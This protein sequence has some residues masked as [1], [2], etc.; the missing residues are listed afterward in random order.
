M[1]QQC[2]LIVMIYITTFL[3]AG[4]LSRERYNILKV[5]FI[6]FI[7]TVVTVLVIKYIPRIVVILGTT[8]VI[9]VLHSKNKSFSYSGVIAMLVQMI[10][11]ITD[12]V[13]PNI[14]IIIAGKDIYDLLYGNWYN[15]YIYG[16]VILVLVLIFSSILG[17]II[18]KKIKIKE[19]DFNNKNHR[20]LVGI[21]A[22]NFFMIFLSVN[23]CTKMGFNNGL[24]KAVGL[25]LSIY[26]IVLTLLLFILIKSI[27]SEFDVKFE[28]EKNKQLKLYTQEIENLYNSLRDF[29][30]D[31][32][33]IL[34][35]MSLYIADK[36]ME[37]LEQYFNKYV[38][39]TDVIV[40]NNE[41]S[42]ANLQLIEVSELKSILAMK[43]IG[44][45]EKSINCSIRVLGKIDNINMDMLDLIRIVGIIFDNAIQAACEVE[46]GT[47]LCTISQKETFKI[48][49]CNNYSGEI[50]DISRFFAKGYTTKKEGSGIGLYNFVNII[51]K[52]NN[53]LYS[54]K[55]ENGLF[56]IQITVS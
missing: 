5:L 39:P 44:A 37:G 4:I 53:V 51:H 17:Y 15:I 9:S 13:I 18:N 24:I 41:F 48:E 55:T 47:V 19:L 54:V 38:L 56:K 23:I 2:I 6:I 49:I 52:Y 21:V 32:K 11:I 1:L 28:R 16:I 14:A 34:S 3:S 42:I 45:K 43:Q 25:L 29:K 7:Q 10:I 27:V 12:V 35:S 20:L 33:N 8:G 22:V 46:N 40:N 36:D 30:H 31:Y 26:T 50:Y